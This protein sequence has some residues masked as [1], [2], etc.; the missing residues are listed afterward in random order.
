M[1]TWWERGL[2]SYEEYFKTKWWKDLKLQLIYRNPKARCWICRENYKLILL[3]HHVDYTKL[4]CEKLNR[5]IFI[6]CMSCHNRVHFSRLTGKK[7]PLT[8]KNLLNR[9]QL[10]R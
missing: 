6:L 5:D 10:L 9:M 1:S 2:S 3:L 7:T 8:R 4:Y